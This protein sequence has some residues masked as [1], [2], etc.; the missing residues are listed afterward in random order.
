MYE[1]VERIAILIHKVRRKLV[2]TFGLNGNYYLWD[3][4]SL[5]KIGGV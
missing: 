4:K 5:G 2:N 1:V 3:M